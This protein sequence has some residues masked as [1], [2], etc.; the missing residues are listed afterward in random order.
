MRPPRPRLTRGR[1]SRGCRSGAVQTIAFLSVCLPRLR[2]GRSAPSL[3]FLFGRDWPLRGGCCQRRPASFSLSA[4]PG[5]RREMGRLD[6]SAPLPRRLRGGRGGGAPGFS[7]ETPMPGYVYA[8][9]C[10]HTAILFLSVLLLFAS[11]FALS[12]LWAC[13]RSRYCDVS[14]SASH[15]SS[16]NY[17]KA[18]FCATW[19]F[20]RPAPAR[21]R[22]PLPCRSLVITGG[23]DFP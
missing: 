22:A 19:L 17:A 21:L 1:E 13:V 16:S 15:Y 9:V 20:P 23:Q 18:G 12:S 14:T 6:I 3:P 5:I 11:L 7:G 10:A 8:C 2:H 4:R